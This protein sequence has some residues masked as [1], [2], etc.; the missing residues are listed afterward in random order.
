MTYTLFAVYSALFGAIMGSFLHVVSLRFHTGKSL[1]GRSHC[2]SCGTQLR[3]Y[4]LIPLVSWII[5]KG[6]CRHCGAKIPLDVFIAELLSSLL[7]LSIA[8][9][10]YFAAGETDLS[11]SYVLSTLYLFLVSSLFL[12]VFFYDARHKIIPDEFSVALAVLTLVGAFFFGFEGRIYTFLGFHI[13]HTLD[14]LAGILIPLPFALIWLL[15]RGILMGLGDPKLMVSIGFLLGL[16]R[17]WSAVF[18][19]FWLGL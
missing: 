10:S 1:R 16:R 6:R 14:L 17:G 5:Q 3:W 9:R 8:L 12:I 13:P 18:L 2:L 11:L 7:F 15:S 19:A 4:E